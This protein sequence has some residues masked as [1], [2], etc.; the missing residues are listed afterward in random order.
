MRAKN[1][2]V[3]L[4]AVL[5]V[6]CMSWVAGATAADLPLG[7]Y[8]YWKLPGEA[9]ANA[10]PVGKPQGAF[11]VTAA[12]AGQTSLLVAHRANDSDCV[13][14]R[15]LQTSTSTETFN[16]TCAQGKMS[17]AVSVV[18]TPNKFVSTVVWNSDQANRKSIVIGMFDGPCTK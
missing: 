2:L 4:K 10:V 6:A 5:V 9:A 1:L 18:K 8:R 11:C 14:T 7:S 16:M 12:N 17:A 3:S 13:T 15:P